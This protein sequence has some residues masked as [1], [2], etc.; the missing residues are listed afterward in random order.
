MGTSDLYPQYPAVG[1][2]NVMYATPYYPPTTGPNSQFTCGTESFRRQDVFPFTP[3]TQNT[4]F[5][6]N[7][8]E[9]LYYPQ[10][11]PSQVT[12]NSQIKISTTALV[13]EFF[14]KINVLFY[15]SLLYRLFS[16]RK[17]Y[18]KKMN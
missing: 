4:D 5:S 7:Y 1:H 15:R 13:Q 8:P 18:C 2:H 11:H 12:V 3:A 9:K 17:H 10:H 14:F 16:L 6:Y